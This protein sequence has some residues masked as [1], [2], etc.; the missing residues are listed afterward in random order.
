MTHR[1]RPLLRLGV[2]AL[3]LLLASSAIAACSVVGSGLVG[4][5]WRVT[6]VATT[7]PAWQAV[8]PAAE[9]LRYTITFA[10]DGTA[11]IK[12]DCNQ[13]TAAYT[14]TPGGTITITPGPST[15]AVCPEGSMGQPFVAALSAVTSYS[16]NGNELTLRHPDNSRLELTGRS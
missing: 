14:T 7:A 11:A 5:T 4:P 3:A 2:A 12:A 8:V 9:S 15:L 13:V 10:N 1:T 6:A 16:V